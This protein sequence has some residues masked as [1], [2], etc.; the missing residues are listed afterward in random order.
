MSSHLTDPSSLTEP[1]GKIA[2]RGPRSSLLG[3]SFDPAFRRATGGFR[4]REGYA[5]LTP[6]ARSPRMY[7]PNTTWTWSFAI[8]TLIQTIVTLGLESYESPNPARPAMGSTNVVAVI[9][10]RISR[11]KNSRTTVPPLKQSP[12]SLPCMA[13]V[14]STNW[15][16][17]TMPCE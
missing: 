10:S 2:S 13:S 14:S 5:N 8:V 15:C 11:S 6:P 9:F 7:L 4:A 16:W 1:P 12:L 3:G 17:S